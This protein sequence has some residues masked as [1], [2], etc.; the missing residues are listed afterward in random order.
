MTGKMSK[1]EV[2]CC[3][4]QI[5]S[6]VTYLHSSGLAHRDLK[7]DNV[8]VSASGIMKIIDFGSAHVFR[9]PFESELVLAS[10]TLR[11]AELFVQQQHRANNLSRD[12]RFGSLSGSRSL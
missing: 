10:G 2:T 9:Y 11:L 5:L 7:L 6:G 8:V 1:A 12:C 4:L 3:F